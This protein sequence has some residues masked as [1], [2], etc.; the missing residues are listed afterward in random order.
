MGES[1]SN[2]KAS[3]DSSRTLDEESNA[4]GSLPSRRTS[5]TLDEGSNALGSLASRRNSRTLD[6]GSNALG[7]L[8]SRRNSRTLDEGSNALGSLR[9]RRISRRHSKSGLSTITKCLPLKEERI[10]IG[11]QI[12]KALERGD[13]T[14]LSKLLNSCTTDVQPIYNKGNTALHLAV[15]SAC[16]KDDWG[17]SLFQCINELMSCEQLNINRPNN[18][19]C[20][21]IGLAVN[22]LHKKCVEYMLRHSSAD[23]LYLDYYPGDSEFTV[24]EIIM[25]TYP[26]FQE[27]LPEPLL[28]SMDSDDRDTKLLAALQRGEYDIFIET[29]DPD[30]PNPWYDEPYHSYLLEIACQMKNRQQFVETLLMMGADPNIK[31]PVTGMTVLHA[32]AR[33]ENLELLELLLNRDKID[34]SVKD[35]EHRTILHWWA[36]VSEKNPDENKRLERCFKLILQKKFGKKRFQKNRSFKDKDSSGNTPF[37]FAVDRKYRDRILLMLDTIPD[38]TTAAHMNQVLDSAN[39]TLLKEILDYCFDSNDEPTN[40]EE[41]KVYLKVNTLKNMTNFAVDSHNKSIMKHPVMS[42]FVNLIWKELKFL[43]FLNVAFYVTFLLFLTAYILFFSFCNIQNIRGVAN[44]TDGLPS[45]I[46]SNVTCG[47]SDESRYNISQCLWYPLIILW[48]VIF[49]RELCQLIVYRWDHI[50]SLENWLELLLLVVTFTSFSGVVDSSEGNRHLFAIA[51]LLGWFELV[52]ILGRLPLLSVQTEMLKKVSLTF[53]KFM[54]GYI[55]LIL[56]FAFS[57]YILFEENAEVGDAVLFSNPLIS[58]LK[59]IVMFAGE[60]EISSLPFDILPGTSHVIFLLF[61]LFVA[62][63]LL[64]L[65]QGL[66]VGDTNK[67]REVA[68]TLSLVARVRFIEYIFGVYW[69]LPK[70]MRVYLILEKEVYNIFPNKMKNIG[71]TDLRSLHNIINEKRERSKK[72]KTFEH[73]ENWRVFAEKLTALQLQSEEIQQTLK[74]LLT[75]LNIPEA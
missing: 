2:S 51:I 12:Y 64:N 63:V 37:S 55:V 14:Q 36:R 23:R 66:A 38:K 44:N 4:L 71:F 25:Q 41:L 48:S 62:I 30:K 47:M 16:Q 46:D 43:S 61:V 50:M 49:V 1:E 45:H 19:G 74:K 11:K 70:F 33:S 13:Y 57:F 65:L 24:R 18:N 15:R 59:T 72:E 28:E 17:G 10:D 3:N 35:N 34:V 68:E 39:K 58:I 54:A 6:E 31:N 75:H 52:L 60:Y 40:S 29:L 20:T 27:I 5:R 8:P 73:V 42:I 67:V 21:A 32:T 56:A 69:A 22:E 9:S 53:L 7:S 26:D